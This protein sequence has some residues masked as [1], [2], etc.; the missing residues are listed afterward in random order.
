[1]KEGNIK[2]LLRFINGFIIKYKYKDRLILQIDNIYIRVYTI[3]K[4]IEQILKKG[5][6]NEN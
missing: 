2:Y 4:K 3:Y 1:M 6:L 5:D